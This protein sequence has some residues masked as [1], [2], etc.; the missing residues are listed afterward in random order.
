M[1]QCIYQFFVKKLHWLKLRF[2]KWLGLKMTLP[3]IEGS[4][5][6]KID[7]DRVTHVIKHF[8]SGECYFTCK[9]DGHTRVFEWTDKLERWL[10]ASGIVFL[11]LAE[12]LEA[13]PESI[14]VPDDGD[15]DDD[16]NNYPSSTELIAVNSK[17]N[18]L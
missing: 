14:E 6:Q 10:I 11:T 17:G 5:P 16:V 18:F 15:N 13:V 3:I 9:V 12:N 2:L 1:L 8:C 4:N 7:S